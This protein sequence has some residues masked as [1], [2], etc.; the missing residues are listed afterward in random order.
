MDELLIKFAEALVIL[1]DVEAS[2]EMINGELYFVEQHQG[3]N[4]ELLDRIK[5]VLAAFRARMRAAPLQ[6]A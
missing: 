5:T 6:H 2:F 1:E 4:A 3:A